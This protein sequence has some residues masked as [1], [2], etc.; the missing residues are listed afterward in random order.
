MC[1]CVCVVTGLECPQHVHLLLMLLLLLQDKV[2][3]KQLTQKQLTRKQKGRV[4]P[5]YS[6]RGGMWIG[7]RSSH[8]VGLALWG[9]IVTNSQS[10]SLQQQPARVRQHADHNCSTK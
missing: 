5:S 10:V 9:L 3:R 4:D 7:S 6:G 2:T 1:S 8:G